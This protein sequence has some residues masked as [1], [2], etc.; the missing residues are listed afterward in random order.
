[1]ALNNIILPVICGLIISAIFGSFV[2]QKVIRGISRTVLS[3]VPL[4]VILFISLFLLPGLLGTA[5][6]WLPYTVCGGLF[7]LFLIL[8]WKP[9]KPKTRRITSISILGAVLALTIAV[10][11]IQIYHNSI[12]EISDEVNL[13]EYEPFREDT[14]AKSLDE[15]SL[16]RLTDNLPRLDGATALYP[17]YAAF[18][19]AVYPQGEYAAYGDLRKNGAFPGTA[20]NVVVCSRTSDAFY[21]LINGDADIAFLMGLSEE[22]KAMAEA[23]GVELKLTPIGHEAFV[24]FV[25][26]R[27]PVSALTVDEIKAIYTGSITNWREVGGKNNAITAYQRPEGS[28]SQT[29]LLEIM[30]GK[31]L[32]PAPEKDVFSSMMGMYRAVADYKNYKN[33]LGYSFMIY[34]NSM[35][36]EGNVKL[37][38]INGAVPNS[39]NISD[40]TYPF[41][42]DFYAVTAIRE[43][44]TGDA[45]ARAENT[46]RFIEWILSPQGQKLVE[47][48]GYV[49]LGNEG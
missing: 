2:K 15:P 28:G 10:S 39:K 42:N 20:S 12:P 3:L 16:L 19:Q 23:E 25:N 24:F 21:N 18:V 31:P 14:L 5:G 9:F 47:L 41:T 32:M 38:S 4:L 29:A 30:E 36:G 40:G 43:G 8:I 45:L 33:A 35:V 13:S 1:M 22:Q 34:I 27:N 17:L 11:G 44:L 26:E 46:E 7:L 49:P 48:T 6:L 37:L